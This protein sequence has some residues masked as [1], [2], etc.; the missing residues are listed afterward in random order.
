[1]V[2][3]TVCLWAGVPEIWCQSGSCGSTPAGW[4]DH[5][6]QVLKRGVFVCL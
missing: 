5:I 3:W 4:S 1:V 2:G 6:S